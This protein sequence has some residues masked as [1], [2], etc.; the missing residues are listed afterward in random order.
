MSAVLAG[1]TPAFHAQGQVPA[2]HA[3]GAAAPPAL[4]AAALQRACRSAIARR[5][6]QRESDDV[7]RI[8]WADLE[9]A[10]A[11]LALNDEALL[12][13]ARRVGAVLC[14]PALR[15]WIDTAR[16][17]AARTAVGDLFWQVLLA[18]PDPMTPGAGYVP[19][20]ESAE[21]VAPMLA[22][23]GLA[24]LLATLPQGAVRRV[25]TATLAR[26]P[27]PQV[28]VAHA[29]STCERADAVI[30]HM[31]RLAAPQREPAEHD[32]RRAVQ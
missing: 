18:Q 3:P 19:P 11:W 4:Q 6:M 16:I 27:L 9:A 32:L 17:A 12:Q 29:R 14:A 21:S 5:L 20:L 1:A 31:H 13:Y 7:A 2:A 26:G 15:L 25:A 23:A 24:A 28:A 22:K 30:A 8:S 10:P